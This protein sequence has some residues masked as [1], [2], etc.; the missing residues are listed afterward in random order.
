[1]TPYIRD[2]P[3]WQ[4][5]LPYALSV[6][7][8]LARR[9]PLPLDVDSLV[10][11][12]LWRA[13][14]G[15]AV[16]S[17]GYVRLRISGAVK[18]EMRRVAEGQRGNYQDAGAFIDVDD[19][20]GIVDGSLVDVEATL[21]RQRTMDS[22]PHAARH[23][24]GEMVAGK[25]LEEIAQDFRVTPARISQV[26]AQLRARPSSVTRLP[27]TVDLR[28]ELQRAAR[29]FLE[30]AIAG[31]TNSTALA[32]KIGAARTTAFRWVGPAQP[33]PQGVIAGTGGPLQTHLHQ[34]GL[35]LVG[36]AFA[37]SQGSV[38]VA[39][40]LLGCSVMTARRWYRQLPASAVDR[41]V[42]Q[43]LST[44]TMLEL[45]GQGLTPHEIGKRLGCSS[46]A[47]RWRLSRASSAL[48]CP[49]TAGAE[50]EGPYARPS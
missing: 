20:G 9:S 41:R 7:R 47:V 25:A 31:T 11:E 46:S 22:L 6:A 5:A 18:D 42:R 32:K 27:G 49:T 38:D 12:A 8:R 40:R 4:D 29:R 23:L 43:D 33:L 16:L 37:R 39:A 36:K 35:G 14:V 19:A 45:R 26:V 13:Q 50:G 1:M 48:V 24:V 10:M 44:A 21:D 34:V 30:Q 28:G 17:K 3:T 2:F 15:G